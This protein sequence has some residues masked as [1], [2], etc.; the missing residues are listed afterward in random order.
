MVPVGKLYDEESGVRLA[1]TSETLMENLSKAE[2]ERYSKAMIKVNRHE[3]LNRKDLALFDK[4]DAL[5]LEY[6]G[7]CLK[8][9]LV[10]KSRIKACKKHGIQ[11]ND[12]DGLVKHMN[13]MLGTQEED[14]DEISSDQEKLGIL[15]LSKLG[16]ERLYE[17]ANAFNSI[18]AN[19]ALTK[20]DLEVLKEADQIFVSSIKASM[21]YGQVLEA[22]DEACDRL[23]IIFANLKT[24]TTH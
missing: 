22:I 9:S 6:H 5:T 4:I 2:K 21:I 8:D 20:A 13:Y 15:L 19:I 1:D 14:F 24:K 3:T 7:M 16:E 23:G 17:F 10:T 18:R 12:R 11:F